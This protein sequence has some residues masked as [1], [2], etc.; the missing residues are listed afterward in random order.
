ML[1]NL[2]LFFFLVLSLVLLPSSIMAMGEDILG[3]SGQYTFFIKPHPGSHITYY[4]RMVP[5]VAT[6]PVPV[7]GPVVQTF[8]VPF[9][10]KRGLPAVISEVPV[11]CAI[12]AGECVDCYPRPSRRPATKEIWVPQP[13]PIS[14][15]GMEFIP[16]PVT[17]RIILPQWFAVTEQPVAPRPVRKV[18]TG[19]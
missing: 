6:K 10:V 3:M 8:P 12:G 13:L 16:R 2:R 11:G 18:G 14:V 19:G 15:R 9:P 4:Q 7:P 1:Q 5:C 17:N